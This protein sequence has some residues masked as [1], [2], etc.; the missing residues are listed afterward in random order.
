MGKFTNNLLTICTPKFKQQQKK[1][2]IKEQAKSK[3]IV[4]DLLYIK[5]AC[6]FVTNC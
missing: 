6:E 4:S 5:R 3:N 1:K 2:I